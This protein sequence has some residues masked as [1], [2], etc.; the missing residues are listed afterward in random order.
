MTKVCDWCLHPNTKKHKLAR[1]CSSCCALKSVKG[2]FEIGIVRGAHDTA[3][4]IF[5]QLEEAQRE[6]E[7]CKK[8]FVVFDYDEFKKIKEL[9]LSLRTEQELKKL[10]DSNGT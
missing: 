4:I 2:A 10:G 3:N 9:A 1:K 8:D 7:Y 5:E 6:C